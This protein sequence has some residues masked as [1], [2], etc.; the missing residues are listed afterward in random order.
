MKK[1]DLIKMARERGIEIDETQAD[2][3]ITLSDEELENLAVAGGID[4][5]QPSKGSVRVEDVNK[6]KR[7]S[8]YSKKDDENDGTCLSCKHSERVYAYPMSYCYCKIGVY[9]N[10]M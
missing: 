3:Y 2:K 9:S 1:E 5:C 8:S 4:R 10:Y 6:G 7:C